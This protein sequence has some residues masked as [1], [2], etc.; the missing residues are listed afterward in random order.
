MYNSEII[1]FESFLAQKVV[2]NDDLSKIVE[3][4]D[5]WIKPRT[6]ISERRISTGLNTSDMCIEAGKKILEK[7]NT[8]PEEIDLI[9]VAT[10]TPDYLSPSTACIVQGALDASNAFAFDINAA[11]SGF[12][13]A[14]STAD[15][16]MKSGLYK[17][18]LVFGAD[19]NSKLVDWQDRGTCVL[20][21]DGCG[22]ALIQASEENSSILAEDMHSDGSSWRAITGGQ[23]QVENF[24]T[25]PD[26]PN[27]Q[28][29]EM[30]GR[31]V[32][33]FATKKVPLSI[34]EVVKK[35][36]IDFDEIKYI[37]PHQANSRIVEAI[38]K[39]LSLS[40]DKF[41]MN[42]DKFGN[43]SAASI[44]IAIAEMIEKKLLQKG[45]KIIIT[46]FGA[47]LTWGTILLKI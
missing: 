44:P 15:K 36:G 12:V 47:G 33:G 32:F 19:L 8:K 10:I 28:Y 23:M 29:L 39:K 24:L 4:S 42:L 2:T 6:G 34:L 22:A 16:F 7:T 17:K 38:A 1:A 18:A 30:D 27:K 11:C 43:T 9:I 14:L 3:T 5:E 26:E 37:V 41:Y 35:A 21:G 45:D 25:K 20:F 13:Y 46:G 31:G 40:M